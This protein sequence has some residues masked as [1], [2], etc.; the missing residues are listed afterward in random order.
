LN[1]NS[2]MASEELDK[3]EV[4]QEIGKGKWFGSDHG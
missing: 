3:Y 1:L 2:K 4:I